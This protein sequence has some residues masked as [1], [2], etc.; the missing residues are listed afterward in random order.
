MSI[1]KKAMMLASVASMIDQFNMPNIELLQSIGYSVDVAADFTNPGNI[2]KERAA[3]LMK[4]LEAMGVRV[5]DIAIPRSLNP[6]AVISAYKKVK[7]L[8]LIEHYDLIHCHSPIGGA[9][10][11]LA[12]KNERKNGTRVIYTAHGF[13]FYDGAP[14]KNWIVFYPVEKWLSKYTDVLITI[15]KEDYKRA[16]EKFKAKKTVYVPGIGV[17]TE[18]FE[19]NNCGNKV[20]TELGIKDTDIMLLSVGE[21]NDNKNHE[22]VIRALAELNRENIYYLICGKG[23]MQTYLSDLAKKY[24]LEDQVKLLGYIKDVNRFYGCADIF[25]F[26]S[27]REGLGLAALEAMSSGLPLITSNIRGINDYSIPNVTGFSCS[28]NDF[29]AL[30]GHIKHLIDDPDLRYRMGRGNQKLVKRFDISVVTEKMKSIYG[31]L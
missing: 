1:Q 6:K 2:S 3:E 5:I 22:I 23:D 18:K 7:E 13:H 9:I 4:R 31:N 28:P 29:K 16:T 26:M 17:D 30:A 19:K 24:K 14:L 27:K 8:I 25:C 21:L 10:T 12:A 11:R 15:N 20:R